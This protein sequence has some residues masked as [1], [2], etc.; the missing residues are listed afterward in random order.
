M[1]D[2]KQ[3]QILKALTTHLEGITPGNGYD[4]DLSASVFRG[5]QTYGENDAIPMLSIIESLQPDT[6]PQPADETN[7]TRFELWI[8]LLQGFIQATVSNPTDDAY[9][10]KAAVEKRLAEIVE[11]QNGRPVHPD[12]YRLNGLIA[13][14]SI[15][16]GLVSGPR[17]EVSAYS[18]FYLPLGV[19]LVV[20]VADPY[21]A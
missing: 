14:L 9:N 11:K 18:F 21:S 6:G 15:G 13:D 12:V 16:P 20:N 17:A 8:L 1:A 5:R 10:L 2:S 7:V 4:F 3:L 19:G